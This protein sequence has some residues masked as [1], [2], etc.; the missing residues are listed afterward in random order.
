MI[1]ISDRIFYP[2]RIEFLEGIYIKPGN[3]NLNYI[4]TLEE[5][6]RIINIYFP[7]AIIGEQF[8][9]S[10]SREIIN[11]NDEGKTELIGYVVGNV[12]RY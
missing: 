10:N 8:E 7:N 6:K 3:F 12:F 4:G 11:T 5:C 2:Y 9:G 1:N